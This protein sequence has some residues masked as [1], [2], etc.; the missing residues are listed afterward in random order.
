MITQEKL[1]EVILTELGRPDWDI[2][3]QFL[4]QQIL[5]ARDACADVSNM[6][7]LSRLRGF[8]DGLAYVVNLRENTIKAQELADADL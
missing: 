5:I 4:A 1:D 8:A 3:R 7:E 6:E 2:I